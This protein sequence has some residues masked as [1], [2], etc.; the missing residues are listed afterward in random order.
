MIRIVTGGRGDQLN[1]DVA[2]QPF[3]PR[4]KNLAH[5]SGANLLEHSVV[6]YD[7]ASHGWGGLAGMLGAHVPR[8]QS[9]GQATA[10]PGKAVPDR[11]AACLTEELSRE[12]LPEKSS[13]ARGIA[14]CYNFPSP[15]NFRGNLGSFFGRIP[16]QH[17]LLN[18]GS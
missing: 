8:R 18:T 16:R 7:L 12:S 13:A 17:G 6:T 11:S 2:P 14:S 10:V 9:P 15:A 1:G 5:G 4:P 3:I